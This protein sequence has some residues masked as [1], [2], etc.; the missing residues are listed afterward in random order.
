M[1]LIVFISNMAINLF[2]IIKRISQYVLEALSLFFQPYIKFAL[3]IVIWSIIND[4][5]S[6]TLS[7][8]VL[9][10]K[11]KF[12]FISSLLILSVFFL[13]GCGESNRDKEISERH[14]KNRKEKHNYISNII[15]KF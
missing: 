11:Y 10:K 8:S 4:I 7:F 12:S 13:G 9:Y 2:S 5:S 3:G 1:K 15:D 6:L 14:E